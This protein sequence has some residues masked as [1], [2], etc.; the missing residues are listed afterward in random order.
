MTADL[1]R[2]EAEVEARDHRGNVWL[3]REQLASAVLRGGLGRDSLRLRHHDGTRV[4]WRWPRRDAAYGPL[5]DTLQTWLGPALKLTGR[6]RVPEPPQRRSARRLAFQLVGSNLIALAL[7]VAAS[8]GW[9]DGWLSGSSHMN[10]CDDLTPLTAGR[11]DTPEHGSQPH[12]LATRTHQ[13]TVD[14]ALQPLLLDSVDH[15]TYAHTHEEFRDLDG[16]AQAQHNPDA[17]ELAARH[18]FVREVSRQWTDEDGN[19]VSHTITQLSSPRNA[20][21]FDVHVAR[22]SCRFADEAWA[23]PMDAGHPAAIAQRIRY[24]GGGVTEQ[25]AWTRDGRRH[26]LAVHHTGGNPDRQLL[27]QLVARTDPLDDGSDV[28]S[29]DTAHDTPQPRPPVDHADDPG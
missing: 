15:G 23:M 1:T 19:P 24:R 11:R 5:K 16:H 6:R 22:Y 17:R 10:G 20:A 25:A 27:G 29:D 13:T 12:P 7:V 28:V 2:A 26:V 8:A 3:P 21:S 14:R 4:T 18:G 9:L